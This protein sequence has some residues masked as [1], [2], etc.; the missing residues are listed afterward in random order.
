MYRDLARP[1]Y[2][3]VSPHIA[4]YGSSSIYFL[5]LY[6]T[7]VYNMCYMYLFIVQCKVVYEEF[8]SSL[9]YL[10]HQILRFLRAM[11]LNT[12]TRYP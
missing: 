8:R 10:I 5:S 12:S 11:E 6:S 7:C 9:D 3:Y 1:A 2:N 4:I